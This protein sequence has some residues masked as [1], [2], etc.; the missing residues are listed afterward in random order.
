MGK[1]KAVKDHLG[2]EYNSI[3]EMCRHYG[4]SNRLFSDRL[5]RGFSLKEALGEEKHARTQ[6]IPIG[7]LCKKYG[8]SEEIY[9]IGI[10]MGLTP[11]DM[12]KLDITIICRDHNNKPYKS[13]NAMCKAFGKSTATVRNRLKLGW[14]LEDALT[15]D[16]RGDGDTL[17]KV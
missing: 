11:R 3:T 16:R 6:N 8:I 1:T 14:S 2:T 7:E 4:I 15:K 9:K 12:R 13:F 10:E 5:C 17:L